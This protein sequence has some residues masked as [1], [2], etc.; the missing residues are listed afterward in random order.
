MSRVRNGGPPETRVSVAAVR[1]KG[2]PIR[3][4][5]PGKVIQARTGDVSGPPKLGPR[6]PNLGFEQACASTT[7]VLA[8]EPSVGCVWWN[9]RSPLTGKF[10]AFFSRVGVRV[11]PPKAQNSRPVSGG[12]RPNARSITEYGM[13]SDSPWGGTLCS[14][15]REAGFVPGRNYGVGCGEPMEK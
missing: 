5:I 1:K 14:R 4:Q 11:V 6:S 15:W 9:R 2:E 10:A 13:L 8:L 7:T 3:A 12:A